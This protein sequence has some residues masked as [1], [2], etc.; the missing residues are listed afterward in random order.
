MIVHEVVCHE[1]VLLFFLKSIQQQLFLCKGLDVIFCFSFHSLF[2][3]YILKEA[4]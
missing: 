3:S 2:H 1:L 4:E